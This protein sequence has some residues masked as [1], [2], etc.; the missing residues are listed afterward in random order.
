MACKYLAQCPSPR[1]IGT[2]PIYKRRFCMH[3]CQRCARYVL[4]QD[5]ADIELPRWVRPTMM[6]HAEQIL[7]ARLN[8][9]N[10]LPDQAPREQTVVVKR[11]PARRDQT[12]R[13]A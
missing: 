10:A 7:D 1:E 8:G 3:D 4:L 9:F 11:A 2:G 13:T 12:S 6:A 5:N